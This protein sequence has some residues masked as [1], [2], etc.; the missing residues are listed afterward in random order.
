METDYRQ[1]YDFFGEDLK[2]DPLEVLG[3][4]INLHKHLMYVA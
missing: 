1:L 3:T 2:T 4:F